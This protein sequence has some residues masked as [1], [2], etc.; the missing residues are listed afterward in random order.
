M[1]AP[2]P[3]AI[4]AIVTTAIPRRLLLNCVIA[5]SSKVPAG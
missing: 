1:V 2:T 3:R 5:R 4:A